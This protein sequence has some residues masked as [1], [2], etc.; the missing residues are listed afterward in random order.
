MVLGIL[1]NSHK[2][3]CGGVSLIQLQ[4]ACSFIT[5]ETL[6]K[7]FFCKFYEIFKNTYNEE[8]EELEG[9]EEY[10]V[11]TSLA[12]L[13]RIKVP[14]PSLKAFSEKY[15]LKAFK[16]RH[17]DKNCRASFHFRNK[18]WK[19]TLEQ[20]QPVGAICILSLH[21]EILVTKK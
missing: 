16:L 11:W 10:I 7:V 5:N 20:Q 15:Y 6:A 21:F 17:N 12:C 1:Q 19:R 2:N 8:I 14:G 4:V 3:T 13:F 18:H 9:L